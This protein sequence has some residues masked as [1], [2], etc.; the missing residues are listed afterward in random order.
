MET[1]CTWQAVDAASTRAHDHRPLHR[2]VARTST[3]NGCR[4]QQ[5]QH[6]PHCASAQRPPPRS[7]PGPRPGGSTREARRTGARDPGPG[8]GGV[9]AATSSGACRHHSSNCR[10]MPGFVP[11]TST[12][13]Q[14][15]RPNPSSIMVYA[16]SDRSSSV[17]RSRGVRVGCRGAHARSPCH[18]G[19]RGVTWPYPDVEE[20]R[21][22]LGRSQRRGSAF[23]TRFAPTVERVGQFRS[24]SPGV[25]RIT[26]MS[27][28]PSSRSRSRCWDGS[29]GHGRRR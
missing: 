21:S 25:A 6:W 29:P 20:L 9:R 5:F 12:V 1:S 3:A 14:D 26:T 28:R 18:R 7:A 23:T 11:P 10:W 24:R 22:V 8:Q 16:L 17:Q 27:V 4:C 15:I 13:S 2:S 19:P